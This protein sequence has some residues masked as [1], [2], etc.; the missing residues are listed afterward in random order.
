MTRLYYTWSAD[1]KNQSMI[2]ES[3]RQRWL[4]R[5]P[6]DK[7]QAICRL[8]H[9]G[10]QDRSLLGL[11][12]LSSAARE[13]RILDP[14]G[15]A[16][17]LA[18]IIYP[19][20][21]KPRWQHQAATGFDFNISHSANLV[22]TVVSETLQVG[23][24]VE[25]IRP[26]RRLNFRSVMRAE[27]LAIIQHQP[28]RFFELWSIKEAVVKAADSAGLSRMREVQINNIEQA[29]LSD[30]VAHFDNRDWYVHALSIAPGFCMMVAASAPVVYL[31][32]RV[33]A[34]RDLLRMKPYRR[35]N[36][37]P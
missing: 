27:E 9:R 33:L 25:K 4:A 16:F 24:D 7:K 18:D 12:L 5:L 28:A 1:D 19:D 37:A 29:G 8:L 11:C 32:V 13:M 23:V 35:Y 17:Q 26:L 22:V 6:V 36:P 2:D 3:V 15:Q 10:H 34:I 20:S 21:G 30:W 14:L 31:P